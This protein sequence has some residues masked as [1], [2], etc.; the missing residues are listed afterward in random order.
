MNNKLIKY[1]LYLLQKKSQKKK[2]EHLTFTNTGKS[3]IRNKKEI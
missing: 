1:L 3:S 2:I